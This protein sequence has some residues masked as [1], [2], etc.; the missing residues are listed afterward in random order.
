MKLVKDNGETLIIEPDEDEIE[1]ESEVDTNTYPNTCTDGLDDGL[2]SVDLDVLDDLD[3][4]DDYS[5]YAQLTI[6]ELEDIQNDIQNYLNS[7]K[8]E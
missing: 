7:K 3:D 5:V 6:D 1:S 4:L 2:D 8:E